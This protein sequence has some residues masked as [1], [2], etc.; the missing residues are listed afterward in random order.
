MKSTLGVTSGDP[1]GVGPEIILQV[2]N[3][4][5]LQSRSNLVV[6]GDWQWLN[7]VSRRVFRRDIASH[8]L[9]LFPGEA[10]R[11]TERVRPAAAVVDLANIPAR[12]VSLGRAS[13]LGGRASGDYIEAA[14]RAAMEGWVDAVVTAPIN[15]ISFHGTRWGRSARGHTEM[16]A[17]LTH[18]K[19]YGLMMVHG[20]MRAIH[21]T[22]HIPLRDVPRAITRTRVVETI[23]L[24]AEAARSLGIVRPRIAVC[25]LNP[26]AGD[27]GLLGHEE[28]R[29][30]APAIAVC[31][32]AGL[33]VE[34]PLSADV[35]WP[36]VKAGQYDIGVAMYHDQGQIP[37]KLDGFLTDRKGHLETHGVNV[38]VGLP[39]VRTSVAHGTAYDIAGQGLASASSLIEALDLAC[40]MARRRLKKESRD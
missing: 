18:S 16:I 21:V 14:V 35:V 9:R 24:A 10:R 11:V 12:G 29:V 31:R 27:G 13:L 2:L 38:T 26:H 40:Q 17:A 20:T 8:V 19:I 36:R 3:N 33:R 22:S 1:A 15:K 6:F 39:I 32:G 37:V 5:R 25:G 34:G 23:R 4:K 28:R 7:T 30:I